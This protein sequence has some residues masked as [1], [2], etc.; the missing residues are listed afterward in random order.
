MLKLGSNA[1]FWWLLAF[2]GMWPYDS[3]LLG[4]T[5]LCL[6]ASLLEGHAVIA[7]DPLC[8][9]LNLVPSAKTFFQF[10]VHNT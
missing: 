7:Q 10:K 4:V 8:K 1:D 3:N 5:L 2:L 6:L 9:V